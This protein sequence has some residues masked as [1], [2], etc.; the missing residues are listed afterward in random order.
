MMREKIRHCA[1]IWW[2]G[3]QSSSLFFAAEL[4]F[5]LFGFSKAFQRLFAIAQRFAALYPGVS[6]IV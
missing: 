6:V 5:R 3:G 2:A 4:G 1:D